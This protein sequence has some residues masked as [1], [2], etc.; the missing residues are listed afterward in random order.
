MLGC[1]L[2]VPPMA[3]A[4]GRVARAAKAKPFVSKAARTKSA[5]KRASTRKHR[6]TN[7]TQLRH[8]QPKVAVYVGTFNPI[9]EGHMRVAQG[10]IKKLGF[11]EVVIVPTANPSHK[12]N[13]ASL[14]DRSAMVKARVAGDKKIN[15]YTGDS[16]VGFNALLRGIQ[17]QR[18]SR[19][20]TL[21]TGQDSFK[22]WKGSITAKLPFDVAVFTRGKKVKA[23]VIPKAVRHKVK[24][25]RNRD[26]GVS[27]TQI[28]EKLGQGGVPS[29][30][31]LHP[32]VRDYAKSRNLYQGSPSSP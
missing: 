9:H 29:S 16:S 6:T 32:V 31:Q 15:L 20:V 22:A 18:G 7:R 12:T 3:T 30:K 14:K 25:V 1:Q 24:V 4:Q 11:D 26:D 2:V 10:A 5:A 23:P 27:S 28:R 21:L 19:P 17:K 8:R 13:V